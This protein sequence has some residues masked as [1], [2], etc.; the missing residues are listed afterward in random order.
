MTMWPASMFAKRRTMS[1]KGLVNMPRISTGIMMGRSQPGRPGGTRPAKWWTRPCLLIPPHCWAAKEMAA[2]AM[3]TAML[4]VAVAEKG[5]SP[6]SAATRMKKKNESSR[7]VN[8]RPSPWPISFSAISSRTK[9]TSP[10]TAAAK[11]V[12]TPSLR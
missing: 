7:G 1:A 5:R 10:S 6:K 2:R 11:P 9:S 8:L 4:P 3:V 12:G